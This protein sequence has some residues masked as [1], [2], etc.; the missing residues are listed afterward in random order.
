[1][2]CSKW[3]SPWQSRETEQHKAE[4]LRQAELK[5]FGPE[6]KSVKLKIKEKYAA[7]EREHKH[8]C[9]SSAFPYGSGRHSSIRTTMEIYAHL[10]M[11]Q[12]RY[13][14]RSMEDLKEF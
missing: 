13:I 3:C 10:D 2:W 8:I 4:E 1:M 6:Q 11:T 14:P 7:I 9:G 5:Y 12:N